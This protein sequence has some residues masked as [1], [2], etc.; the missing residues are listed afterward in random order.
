MSSALGRPEAA[1]VLVEMVV[2]G[3]IEPGGRCASPRCRS[4]QRTDRG[5]VASER[6]HQHIHHEL[7]DLGDR[8]VGRGVLDRAEVVRVEPRARVV[9]GRVDSLRGVASARRGRQAAEAHLDLA[10]LRQVLVDLL[11]VGGAEPR[12]QG[13]VA[14]IEEVEDRVLPREATGG[15]V[16]GAGVQR[17]EELGEDL[18]RIEA[19]RDR[20][21]RRGVLGNSRRSCSSAGRGPSRRPAHRDLDARLRLL[22]GGDPGG[23]HPD[24]RTARSPKPPWGPRGVPVSQAMIPALVPLHRARLFISRPSRTSSRSCTGASGD[25]MGPRVKFVSVP[26]GRQRF[27]TVPPGV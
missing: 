25:R 11:L 22:T 2:L 14:P 13:G 18:H 4:T 9:V 20:A 17:A 12:G 3:Q 21:V 27:I 24:R 26:V 7:A 19:R 6:H 10:E 5:D 16:A 1:V 15:I 23:D 8:R